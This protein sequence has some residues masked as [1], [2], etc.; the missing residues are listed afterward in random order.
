MWAYNPYVNPTV[1][2]P[3]DQL[4]TNF[5]ATITAVAINA[6]SSWATA[7]RSS[8]EARHKAR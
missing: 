1:A 4:M 3:D 6:G 8:S 2:K 5:S 7:E